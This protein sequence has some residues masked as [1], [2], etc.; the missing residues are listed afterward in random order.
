MPGRQRRQ[1]P[2]A[3]AVAPL[4]VVMRSWAQMVKFLHHS[5]ATLPD[6]A[7]KSVAFTCIMVSATQKAVIAPQACDADGL[8]VVTDYPTPQRGP[9]HVRRLVMTPPIGVGRAHNGVAAPSK[10]VIQRP[11]HLIAAGPGGPKV[12]VRQ[13]S[14]HLRQVWRVQAPIPQSECAGLTCPPSQVPGPFLR[15]A[16]KLRER[17]CLALLCVVLQ[18]AWRHPDGARRG[19]YQRFLNYRA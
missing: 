1:G 2:R 14:R 11:K 3:K 10:P 13:P 16:S 8:Q 15:W 12:H 4:A 18:M 5:F 17:P 19:W 6:R 7:R 9:G